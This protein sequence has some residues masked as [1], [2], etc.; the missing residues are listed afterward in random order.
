MNKKESSDSQ[1]TELSF[2]YR[3]RITRIRIIRWSFAVFVNIDIV[4]GRILSAV[5]AWS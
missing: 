3:N 2:C 1:E 5:P 4:C